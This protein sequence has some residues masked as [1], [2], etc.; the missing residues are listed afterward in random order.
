MPYGF[1]MLVR[2]A[3]LVG[4]AILAYEASKDKNETAMIVFIA[5]AILFQP[6]LKIPLGRTIW[7]V[8]D[9]LVAIGLLASIFVKQKVGDK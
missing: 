8:L 3:A 6:F 7:N 1:F 9:V 2:F 4:F 5:L